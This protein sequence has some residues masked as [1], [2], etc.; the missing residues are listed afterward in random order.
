MRSSW[1]TLVN[2]YLQ[3]GLLRFILLRRHP[4]NFQNMHSYEGKFGQV[5][6]NSCWIWSW[7]PWG[8]ILDVA[9]MV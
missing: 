4:N 6:S 2:P 7:N 8:A 9:L 1:I 3:I 5:I